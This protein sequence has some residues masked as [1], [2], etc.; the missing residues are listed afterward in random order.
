MSRRF[1]IALLILTLTALLVRVGVCWELAGADSQVSRPAES[2]DMATY[3]DLSNRVSNGEFKGPFY[4]QPFY[5]AV[6]LPLAKM[7]FGSGPWPVMLAQA[8]LG[9]V[10]VWLVGVSAGLLAGRKAALTAAVLT[11]FSQI[12]IL[13]VPY[14]LIATLQ[15]FWVALILYLSLRA[16]ASGG[17][18]RWAVLGGVLACGVLTRG[19]LWFFVPGVALLAVRTGFHRSMFTGR[20]FKAASRSLRTWWPALALMVMIALPQIPFAWWNTLANG[21]LSGPSTA[22]GAVLALGNTPE[23]PP[24]GRNPGEG[25]GPME[26]P[27]TYSFWTGGEDRMSI[28]ARI[29]TWAWREPLAVAELFFRKALLFWDSREIPNNIA[30]EWQGEMSDW[31]KVSGFVSTGV[32]AALGLA[33]TLLASTSKKLRL[34][35]PVYFI[36]AYWLATLAFYNL[37]RFRVPAVPLLA[38]M[39]G[40]FVSK[41]ITAL[42]RG[43]RRFTIKR[44]AP[45]FVLGAFTV[46][47]AYDLY[48]FNLEPTVLGWARPYGTRVETPGG[49]V[50]VLDHG[51]RTFGAWRGLPIKSGVMIQKRFIIPSGQSEGTMT[52][53]SVPLFWATP[54]RTEVVLNGKETVSVTAD[55][56]GKRTLSITSPIPEKGVYIVEFPEVD[57][58]LY[59]L[60]DFQRDYGRTLIDGRKVPC[61]LVARVRTVDHAGKDKRK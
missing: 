30:V 25:P 1:T 12:L 8:A 51:P 52:T 39:G 26:Y 48:R 15:A 57:G 59:L 31:L 36:A 13:Y 47:L 24:G 56:P 43:E 37:A 20:D 9:A 6:F 14:H 22:A 49:G 2:T 58:E 41:L 46:F 42:R 16:V 18:A 17:A 55:S 29:A 19:N 3:M 23:A 50:M 34:W 7:P 60:G 4:Y 21:R 28:P 38:V 32:I 53:L 45:P 40:F 10:T 35:I 5:Y 61:E 27:E 44:F 11:A 33:G 54:G